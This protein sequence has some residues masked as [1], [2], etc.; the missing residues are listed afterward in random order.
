MVISGAEAEMPHH[1][2]LLNLHDDSP[3]LFS[4]FARLIEVVGTDE[5]DRAACAGPGFASTGIAATRYTT[6][7]LA[8][9]RP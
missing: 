8:E 1:D 4:R 3:P 5:D 9:S 7:D 6:D 2:V